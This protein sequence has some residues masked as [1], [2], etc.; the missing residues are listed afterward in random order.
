MPNPRPAIRAVPVIAP[1]VALLAACSA[2]G[3][4]TTRAGFF[5]G[6]NLSGPPVVIDEHRREGGGSKIPEPRD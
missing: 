3:A 5:R 6:P 4:E 1:A 2:A